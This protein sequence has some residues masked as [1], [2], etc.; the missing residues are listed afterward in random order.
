MI[1]QT[2]IHCV[3][4]HIVEHCKFSIIMTDKWQ[5]SLTSKKKNQ[6]LFKSIRK[7]QV[8]KNGQKSRTA[9]HKDET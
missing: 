9:F 5:V 6:K 8:E 1:K 7:T 2:H 4:F 3:I